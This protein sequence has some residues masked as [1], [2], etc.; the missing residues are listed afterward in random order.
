[1]SQDSLTCSTMRA[2]FEIFALDK[3]HDEA[4]PFAPGACEELQ[5][6]AVCGDVPCGKD[7]ESEDNTYARWTPSASLKMVIT[8]P[9]LFDKFKV[10]QKFYVDFSE[11]PDSPK[12]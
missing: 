12:S 6:N 5:M 8:N 10:G 3:R 4:P 2:K 9:A 11:S 1:M 7:G